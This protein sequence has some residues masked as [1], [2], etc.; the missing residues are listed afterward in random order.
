MAKKSN[1]G[2]S[3]VSA[4]TKSNACRRLGRRD[5]NEMV[6]RTIDEQFKD[7]TAMDIDGRKGTDGF[8]LR[9]RLLKDTTMGILFLHQILGYH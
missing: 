7:Y 4:K 9:E 8:S 6:Q 1:V 2:G 3:P 5:T